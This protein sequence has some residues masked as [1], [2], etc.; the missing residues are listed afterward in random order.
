[1]NVAMSNI[2]FG[3]VIALSFVKSKFRTSTYLPWKYDRISLL[4]GME[5]QKMKHALVFTAFMILA[6]VI[7]FQGAI[8]MIGVKSSLLLRWGLP[9]KLGVIFLFA[10]FGAMAAIANWDKKRRKKM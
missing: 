1:M 9:P 2:H 5:P 4:C 6:F 3:E 8:L 10:G 7:S